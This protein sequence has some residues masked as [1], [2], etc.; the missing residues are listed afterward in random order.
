MKKTNKIYCQPPLMAVRFSARP[1]TETAVAV[2]VAIAAMGMLV[3][4]VLAPLSTATASS[5]YLNSLRAQ[6]M[7]N[8]YTAVS[9]DEYAPF[10]NP[11]GLSYFGDNS[12]ITLLDGSYGEIGNLAGDLYGDYTDDIKPLMD[13]GDDIGKVSRAKDLIE[14]PSTYRYYKVNLR[15][16]AYTKQNF[17]VGSYGVL[18]GY[19]VY[20]G[21]FIDLDVPD[22]IDD[23]ESIDDLLDFLSFDPAKAPVGIA[24]TE[25]GAGV[26]AALSRDLDLGAGQLSYGG[27]LR[28]GSRFVGL[29]S[30][31]LDLQVN[32]IRSETSVTAV[33]DLG[34]MY[35]LTRSG[36]TSYRV[37]VSYN[38]LFLGE[39]ATKQKKGQESFPYNSYL[40]PTVL[41]FGGAMI[42]PLGSTSSNR[43]LTV[44]VDVPDVLDN[45]HVSDYRMGNKAINRL[46]YGVEAAL[47]SRLA[48]RSG[49][50]EGYGTLGLGV[51][52]LAIKIDYGYYVETPP[53]PVTVSVG[54]G[55]G[56]ITLFSNR[57]A[58]R[59][60]SVNV[61]FN[62]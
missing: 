36:Q 15:P 6:G 18:N 52:V 14:S 31:H 30:I 55:K 4:M 57:G 29:G 12:K 27:N 44:A 59:K 19:A 37:G 53:A 39:T 51:K 32:Q 11:A 28:V 5:Y 33:S 46:N 50:S 20:G 21:E 10:Y 42:V 61:G 49:L 54:S 8:A 16:L 17:A 13:E 47:G 22:S 9:D 56:D 35:G 40:S 58:V 60:H 43:K 25:S 1:S 41:N 26:Y 3:A 2:A 45:R 7:G 62:F 48:V 34:L 38:N 24:Y 23:F